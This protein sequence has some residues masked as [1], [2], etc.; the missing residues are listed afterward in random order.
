MR[1]EA[2]G[3]GTNYNMHDCT[4]VCGNKGVHYQKAYTTHTAHVILYATLLCTLHLQE[5]RKILDGSLGFAAG[6]RAFN[7]QQTHRC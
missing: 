7:Q 3:L 4:C 1:E 6:V 5:Q 2:W